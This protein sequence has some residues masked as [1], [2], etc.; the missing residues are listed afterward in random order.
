MTSNFRSLFL[1]LIAMTMA[2]SANA[3]FITRSLVRTAVITA[4]VATYVAV[5][6]NCQAVINDET[7][8]KSVKCDL[9][10]ALSAPEARVDR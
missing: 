3:G 5:K 10:A 8:K 9:P 4:G 7:G 6:K 2:G 1:V